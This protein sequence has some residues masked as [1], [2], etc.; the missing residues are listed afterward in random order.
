MARIPT[1]TQSQKRRPLT[2]GKF[3]YSASPEAFGAS[4]LHAD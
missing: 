1:Y 3:T 2:E 4:A